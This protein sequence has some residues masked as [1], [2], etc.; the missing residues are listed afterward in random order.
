MKMA[1]LK[2]FLPAIILMCLIGVILPFLSGC[3]FITGSSLEP[4]TTTNKAPVIKSSETQTTTPTPIAPITISNTGLEGISVIIEPCMDDPEG[5]ISFD[6]IMI[7]KGIFSKTYFNQNGKQ[8]I[9]DPCWLITGVIKNKSGN[10]CWVAYHASGSDKSGNE[11]SK[12]LDEGP[13]IGVAQLSFEKTSSENFTLHQSWADN[14][15]VF[16]IR[17][18]KSSIMFP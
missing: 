11:V 13:I 1:L 10:R 14:V 7:K 17:S 8:E 6:N 15:T 16:R 12:T 4:T 9:N 5:D 18:Q 2:L 3:A